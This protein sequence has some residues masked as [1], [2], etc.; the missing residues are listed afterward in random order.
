LTKRWVT[1]DLDCRALA[2]TSLGRREML[3]RFGLTA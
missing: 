3:S 2:V 1:Q